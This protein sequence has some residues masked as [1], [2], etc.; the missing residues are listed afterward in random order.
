M[1][2]ITFLTCWWTIDKD[3][4]V[5]KWIYD[6]EP[7]NPI[8]WEVF[9]KNLV[10]C[11]YEIVEVLRKDSLDMNDEDR[12]KV[13]EKLEQIEND[14]II[15]THGTDT[16]IQTWKALWNIN[17]KVVVLVGAARPYAMKNSDAEFNL[18]YALWVLDILSGNKQYWVYITMNWEI[19]DVNNVE[20]WEDGVFRK[21]NI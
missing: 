1:K 21:I 6:V 12:N 8:A 5:W 17:D 13:K 14:K 11:D 4:G 20:K 16:M 19:F 3:Y 10:N 9:D 7:W 18:W 15:I 2:K